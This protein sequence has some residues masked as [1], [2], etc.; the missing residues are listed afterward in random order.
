M[1]VV[2]GKKTF[3]GFERAPPEGVQALLDQL[4]TTKFVVT[5]PTHSSA[6]KTSV[7][8]A[9]A[10]SAAA[11]DVGAGAGAGPGLIEAKAAAASG[12]A[13]RWA[14]NTAFLP[15]T[16]AFPVAATS[17]YM[18]LLPA[19]C[20]AGALVVAVVLRAGFITLRELEY[21]NALLQVRFFLVLWN[22]LS[23]G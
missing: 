14:V 11:T 23:I 16:G 6:A 19:L 18:S 20:G 13:T 4:K 5:P 3:G 22:V 15:T 1:A 12:S 7:A 17:G 2:G 9:G 21:L 10:G 8:G